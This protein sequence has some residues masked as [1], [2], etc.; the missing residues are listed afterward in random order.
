MNAPRDSPAKDGRPPLV[1]AIGTLHTD[2]VVGDPSGRVLARLADLTRPPLTAGARR[3]VD[4]PTMRMALRI[5]DPHPSR[6]RPGGS[7][8]TT[9]TA[10]AATGRPLRLALIGAAGQDPGNPAPAPRS[11][12]GPA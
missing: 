8:A 2:V 11:R 9:V 1:A 6:C 7:A 4:A 12:G 3:R 10:V 5:A